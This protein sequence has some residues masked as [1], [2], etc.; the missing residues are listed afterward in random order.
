MYLQIHGAA[1]E[2]P[3][4]LI[5]CNLYVEDCERGVVIVGVKTHAQ[6]FTDQHR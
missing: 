2:Y 3:V 4:L 6:E 5:V 1:M